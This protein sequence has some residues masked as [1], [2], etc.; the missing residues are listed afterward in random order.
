[1]LIELLGG[2]REIFVAYILFSFHIFICFKYTNDVEHV[3]LSRL[4]M[5]FRD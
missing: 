2:T 4:T 1:M 5:Y 3:I